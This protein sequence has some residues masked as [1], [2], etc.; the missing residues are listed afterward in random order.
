M[1]TGARGVLSR[2]RRLRRGRSTSLLPLSALPVG[3]AVGSAAE[4]GSSGCGGA[5]KEGRGG[6]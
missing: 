1:P 5:G 3:T 4:V 2:G 6:E